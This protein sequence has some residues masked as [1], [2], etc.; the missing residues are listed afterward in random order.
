MKGV[1]DTIVKLRE[2]PKDPKFTHGWG[3]SFFQCCLSLLSPKII[4]NGVYK[5]QQMDS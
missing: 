4:S 5:I 1:R 2:N 3:E